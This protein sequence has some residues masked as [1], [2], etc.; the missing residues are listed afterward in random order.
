MLSLSS[1]WKRH[2]DIFSLADFE[3]KHIETGPS[4]IIFTLHPEFKVIHADNVD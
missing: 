4:D 1:A 2:P 3:V